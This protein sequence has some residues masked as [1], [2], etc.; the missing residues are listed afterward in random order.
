MK[1]H[2]AQRAFA[3]RIYVSDRR[4]T[5]TGPRRESHIVIARMCVHTKLKH[6]VKCASFVRPENIARSEIARPNLVDYLIFLCMGSKLRI[7]PMSTIAARARTHTD[8]H[9]QIHMY[10]TGAEIHTKATAATT[11]GLAKENHRSTLV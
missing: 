7:F 9:T 6:R 3:R 11:I 8:T 1:I 4:H 10:T 5:A 2:T